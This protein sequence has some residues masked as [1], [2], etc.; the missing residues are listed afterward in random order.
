MGQVETMLAFLSWYLLSS[1]LG[2]SIFPLVWRLFPALAD[3]GFSLA[4]TFGLLVWGY[5]FWLFA[6]LGF[7]QNDPA[8]LLFTFL[9]VIGL[10]AIRVPVPSPVG[11]GRIAS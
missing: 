1:L 2:W 4:R 7:I 6:S 9:L 5:F 10:G 11:C 3:R 8:G